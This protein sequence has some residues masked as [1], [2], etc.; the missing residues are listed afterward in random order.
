MDVRRARRSRAWLAVTTS[1]L[2]AVRPLIELVGQGAR[3]L[4]RQTRTRIVGDKEELM[5]LADQCEL[6]ALVVL[7]GDPA[8][9]LAVYVCAHGNSP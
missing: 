6:S 8:G 5:A 4:R 2:L 3:R 1:C 9:A 7:H